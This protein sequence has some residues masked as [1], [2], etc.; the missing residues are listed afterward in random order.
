[1]GASEAGTDGE[2]EGGEEE[3]EVVGAEERALWAWE[4]KRKTRWSGRDD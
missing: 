3:E 2:G 1:V 4:R